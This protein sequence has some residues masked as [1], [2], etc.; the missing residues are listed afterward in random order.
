MLN[1]Y[2]PPKIIQKIKNKKK[3]LDV[4]NVEYLGSKNHRKK[5]FWFVLKVTT[6]ARV[7]ER[8]GL[9]YGSHFSTKCL[10]RIFR[11]SLWREAS[12]GV[13]VSIIETLQEKVCAILHAVLRYSLASRLLGGL[14]SQSNFYS[15]LSGKMFPV[16]KTEIDHEI[17]IV[18]DKQ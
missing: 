4:L 8:N 17:I 5:L 14:S 12:F 13:G 15:V 16:G 10:S 9:L 11:S 7:A 1:T 18:G 6:T 3:K 2:A